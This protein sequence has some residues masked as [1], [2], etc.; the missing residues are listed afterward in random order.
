MGHEIALLSWDLLDNR[1]LW[2]DL[3]K[4]F[5]EWAKQN[6]RGWEQY[7]SG[8]DKF[9]IVAGSVVYLR[10]GHRPGEKSCH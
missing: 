10:K 9:E 8:L 3:R 5:L 2:G 7:E 6:E 1:Y 4:D